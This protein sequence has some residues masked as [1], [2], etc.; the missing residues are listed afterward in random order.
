MQGRGEGLCAGIQRC[1]EPGG[2]GGGRDSQGKARQSGGDGGWGD[3]QGQC[4]K[5]HRK[6]GQALGVWGPVGCFIGLEI[7]GLACSVFWVESQGEGEGCRLGT[8]LKYSCSGW[9]KVMK[10]GAHIS[11]AFCF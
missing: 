2:V 4:G 6:G 1:I 10:N 5:K 7:L 11:S 3:V 9:N 8:L